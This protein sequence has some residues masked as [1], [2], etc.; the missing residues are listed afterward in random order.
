MDYLKT[1]GIS[2]AA[3]MGIILVASSFT[4]VDSG[5]S[6]R[7]Q[8]SLNGGYK[9]V[10][11]EGVHFKVPLFS[12]VDT[13]NSVSTIAVTNDEALVDTASA[14]REP[15]L[16]G[17][18]DNYSG[19]IE[20][21]WRVRLPTDP[22]RLER[23]HQEVKSQENLEGN[24]FL[25]F[26]KDMLNLTTDQFLAQNFMQ[27]GKGAFKQ[28][29]SDQATN[30]MLVT[31]REKVRVN[32]QVADQSIDGVRKQNKTTN[33]FQY[34]VV[35]QLDNK[36]KPLRRSHSLAKYGI[37]ITQV[38]LG[39]FIPSKDLQGYVSTI[40][41][42]ERQRA[43]V[44]AQQRME[45]DKA[46]T[47]QLKGDRE[48]ITA[49]NKSL[50]AKDRAVI[51]E[52]QKVAVEQ[53]KA[54]L[55]VVQKNKE[56]AIAKA[57]EGIQK[58]NAAAAR[59]EAQAIKET[60]FAQA[61]VKKADYNAIDKEVLRLEVDK[62]KALALYRSNMTVKMPM[63]VGGSSEGMDPISTMSSLKVLE[64]LGAPVVAK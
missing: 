24:T 64:S 50:M 21:S 5:E 18:A 26:A 25:T 11:K 42:R 54:N 15:L 19:Y 10:L 49:K 16:V 41:Q 61:A 30:G 32:G 31:K 34:K 4:V 23:I 17:F 28:R 6:V 39:E 36:G 48:R 3:L 20:A 45:R 37:E 55:S 43:D 44:V 14:V 51:A 35:V 29:L 13:Y 7:I 63:I 59:Y 60:G 2:F 12:K 40:K 38:D 1:V 33:Q 52:Q 57:N 58:A 62:A 53:E 56:L 22:E 27:G 47:E 9:W 46:V 8:N